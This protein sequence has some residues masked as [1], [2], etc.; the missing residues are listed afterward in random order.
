ME[1]KYFGDLELEDSTPSLIPLRNTHFAQ[2]IDGFPLRT[3]ALDGYPLIIL[4]SNNQ[5]QVKVAYYPS[6]LEFEFQ[7][8]LP[9]YLSMKP[10]RTLTRTKTQNYLRQSAQ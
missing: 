10:S 2:T 3:N 7:T 8:T 5:H 9:Q 4:I 1:T 6:L